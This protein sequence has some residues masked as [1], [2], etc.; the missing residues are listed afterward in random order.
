M[1]VVRRGVLMARLTAQGDDACMRYI[2]ERGIANFRPVGTC[3]MGMDPQSV[4]DPRLHV[5]GVA[6]LRIV[7]ASV[8]P[9]I[10]SGNTN[11]P[12]IM[13]AE[14]AADMI[15]EDIRSRA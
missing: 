3:R 8:M 2:R 11:A 1:F 10:P 4:V 14:K 7:D 9:Q 5:H 12:A 6:G 15:L 13:I